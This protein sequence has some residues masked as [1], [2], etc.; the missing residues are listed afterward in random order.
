MR[1][2][3]CKLLTMPGALVLAMMIVPS[4][5]AQCGLS[6]KLV[7]PANW[8]PQLR[9]AHVMRAALGGL[10][11]DDDSPSIVGMWHVIFTAK[12]SNG[13]AIPNTMIDNSLVQ[14]H[15]DKTEIMNSARPAQDGDFCLG[16]W[17]KTG[18]FT[19]HLNHF[20]WLGGSDTTNAPSGIGNPSGPTRLVESVTLNEDGNHYSGTFKLDAYDTSNN[21]TVSFTGVLTATRITTNTTEG[22]LY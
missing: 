22:E 4:A 6:T 12:T 19:Y 14:W 1:I 10:D 2:R 13:T 21:L 11:D 9:V 7:K 18:R 16:V 5:L 3:N 8:N 15:S 20:A 17:A